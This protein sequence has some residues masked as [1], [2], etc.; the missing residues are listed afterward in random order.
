MTVPRPPEPPDGA[1]VPRRRP[2]QVRSR[3]TVDAILEAAAQVLATTS[4][5]GLTMTGVAN[6]AGVSPGSLYQYFDDKPSLF[7]GLLEAHLAREADALARAFAA[8]ADLPLDRAVE[9]V[10]RAYVG[11]HARD[12]AL[13][14]ALLDVADRV[15]WS[16][17]VEA[18]DR[19]TAGALGDLVA[20][21]GAERAGG[22]PG[23]AAGM[24]ALALRAS[25]RHA[26]AER[27]EAVA[28]EGFADELVRLLQAYLCRPAAPSEAPPDGRP[29]PAQTRGPRSDGG[30]QP[31]PQRGAAP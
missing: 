26:L 16:D 6:R 23:A 28:T 10:V 22:D 3:I 11:V 24:A 14:R 15:G 13:S 4:A 17:G 21:R 2:G 31:G 29:A 12:P 30:R 18:V 9:A 7:G 27:P 19:Q 1:A 20:S 5:D 25:V 8:S